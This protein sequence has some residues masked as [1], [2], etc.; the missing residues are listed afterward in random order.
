[1]SDP[2]GGGNAW[3]YLFRSI[4]RKFDPSAGKDYVDYDFKLT[5]LTGDRPC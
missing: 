1:M 5:G 3:V 2:V 4:N